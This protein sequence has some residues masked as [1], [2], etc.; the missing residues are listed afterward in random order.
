M[1]SKQ[2]SPFSS[3]LENNFV[4]QHQE[5]NNT[6]D[7]SLS[8]L[9]AAYV[10]QAE[11]NKF[12]KRDELKNMHKEP[13][14]VERHRVFRR[15]LMCKMAEGASVHLHVLEMIGL[16][17]QLG[18]LDYE[19]NVELATNIILK[20]LPPS[21]SKFVENYNLAGELKPLS[22]LQSMLATAESSIRGT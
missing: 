3:V 1:D 13:T 16:I 9:H 2:S 18:K 11:H 7:T 14:S 12:E 15:L 10:A 22:E 20:S 4:K 17:D 5:E 21:F 8:N 6:I 19:V